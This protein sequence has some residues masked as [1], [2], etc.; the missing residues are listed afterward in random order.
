MMRVT[1]ILLTVYRNGD[2]AFY[3]YHFRDVIFGRPFVKRFTLCHRTVVCLSVCL[4]CP[5]CDVVVLW[6]NGFTNQDETWRTGRPR[7]W[8]HCVRWEP[9]PPPLKGHVKPSS[10][11]LLYGSLRIFLAELWAQISLSLYSRNIA[12]KLTLSQYWILTTHN[13]VINKEIK[14][15]ITTIKELKTGL[16]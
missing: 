4:S 2:C 3:Y 12:S 1:Q 5:V 11:A 15:F 14:L 16:F 10:K 13:I 7:P 9:A 6:P 8:P